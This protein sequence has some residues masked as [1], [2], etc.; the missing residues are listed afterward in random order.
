[1]EDLWAKPIREVSIRRQRYEKTEARRAKSQWSRTLSVQA[2]GIAS[3]LV[4]IYEFTRF[5]GDDFGGDFLEHSDIER[6]MDGS[7]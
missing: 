4:E 5:L 3:L 1:V 2:P 7:M 6:N